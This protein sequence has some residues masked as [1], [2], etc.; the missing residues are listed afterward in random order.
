MAERWARGRRLTVQDIVDLPGIDRAADMIR[1]HFNLNVIIVIAGNNAVIKI[2][3][4][5]LIEGRL[6]R[7]FEVGAFIIVVN[8]NATF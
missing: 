4:D 8:K 5:I 3:S 1:M 2:R 7:L 6:E